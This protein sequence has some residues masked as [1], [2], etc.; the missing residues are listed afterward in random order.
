MLRACITAFYMLG[1][2]SR[3]GYTYMPYT[4]SVPCRLPFVTFPTDR[5]LD[6]AALF[7]LHVSFCA[8]A[9][10][11]FPIGVPSSHGKYLDGRVAEVSSIV[12]GWLP[13]TLSVCLSAFLRTCGVP[14]RRLFGPPW[15]PRCTGASPARN[16]TWM[17]VLTIMWNVWY[18]MWLRAHTARHSS[19]MSY[20]V[21][22][23]IS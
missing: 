20:R 9:A 8:H 19:C 10:R 21:K 15:W 16:V 14:W 7:P 18:L 23:D 3:E 1:F 13:L 22:R 6:W 12:V 5:D 4:R 11:G 2:S 17:R